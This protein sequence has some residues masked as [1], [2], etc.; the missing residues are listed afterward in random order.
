M[1]N[2]T[3]TN[4]ISG[5]LFDSMIYNSQD[6]LNNFIDNLSKEQANQIIIEAVKSAHSRG[7]FSLQES[8]LV[9]K[10]LRLLLT[11]SKSVE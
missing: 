8:E 7:V 10:S 9:S 1:V 2:D 3:T 6:T 5:K 4:Q 11:P